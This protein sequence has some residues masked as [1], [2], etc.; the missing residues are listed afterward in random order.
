MPKLTQVKE[1]MDTVQ[2]LKTE[3]KGYEEKI[4]KLERI[5]RDQERRIKLLEEKSEEETPQWEEL[6]EKVDGIQNPDW[7]TLIQSV[8]FG[9]VIQNQ[10]SSLIG[11]MEEKENKLR[12]D[13]KEAERR[14]QNG[15]IHNIKESESEDNDERIKHDEDKIQ[16]FLDLCGADPGI[17]PISMFRIGNRSTATTNAAAAPPKPRPIKLIFETEE[18]KIHVVK[19]YSFAKREGGANQ[20][21]G[22]KDI[23][24]VPDRTKREREEF[25]KLI[26]ERDERTK[27]GEV[28]LVIINGKIKE[29]PR[30]W[31]VER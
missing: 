21:E 4:R 30:R 19:K 25:Q 23:S 26:S 12:E 18:K 29:K 22:L 9:Q 3:M 5:T 7:P 24:L 15:I 13:L 1:L 11:R 27:N 28:N 31:N 6:K 14:K 20:K 17:K 8:E 10:Q 2:T 16:E